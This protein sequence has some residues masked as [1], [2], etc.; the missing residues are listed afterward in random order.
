MEL[1]EA[2]LERLALV[3]DPELGGSIVEL[4]MV[5]D[6][7]VDAG[8]ARVA[9]AL[10]TAA[11]PLRGVIERDVRDAVLEIE[12]VSEVRIE[13]GVMDPRAK[14]SLMKTARGLAQARAPLTSIPRSAPIIMVASGKGGVGKSSVTVNL[15][16]A[17]LLDINGEVQVRNKKMLPLQRSVDPGTV[18][19]LS[20]GHLSDER[21]AVMWRGLVVQKAV[22]QFI[23]DADWSDIDI[24]VIDTPP[25]TGDIVMTLARLLPHMGQIVVTT[26][27]RAAQE[28]AAR[29]A[30]FASRSNIRLLGVVENMS[31]F[32][33]ECGHVH[34]PLGAGGGD[35]L[36][37]ELTT[38]LLARIPLR[39]DLVD[40]GD[41][42]QPVALGEDDGGLFHE[43]ARRVLALA[44]GL[45][46]LVCTARMHD[47]IDTAV[48]G[49]PA[50]PST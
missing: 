44:P 15:A 49:S 24:M 19:L 12:G 30:D 20:M 1:R 27:S 11:C 18:S 6:V 10:T 48:A 34:S 25:G 41:G 40:G 13:L 22:S 14:A 28:V 26:P 43:L 21:H 32:T 42:G 31:G 38:E 17:R 2:I 46:R 5:S 3:R 9:I 29:A 7:I 33:C 4:G 8:V 39:G 36:A 35:D 23:E 16:I 45:V 47:A 37:H 50:Y